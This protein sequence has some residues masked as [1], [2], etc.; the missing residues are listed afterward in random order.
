LVGRHSEVADAARV[1]VERDAAWA[2]ESGV[3]AGEVPAEDGEEGGVGGSLG[4]GIGH[5]PQ[6]PRRDAVEQ[7]RSG[8]LSPHLGPRGAL[9]VRPQPS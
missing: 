6:L 2:F 3:D 8:W 9:T 1:G 4:R 5:V 7:G